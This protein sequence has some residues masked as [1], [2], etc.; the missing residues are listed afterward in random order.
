MTR[1]QYYASLESMKR[2]FVGAV[3]TERG[4]RLNVSRETVA[5]ASAYQAVA[6]SR[7]AMRTKSVDSKP[8]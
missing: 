5:E 1:D 3:M 4:D 2:A 6:R 7:P 8:R